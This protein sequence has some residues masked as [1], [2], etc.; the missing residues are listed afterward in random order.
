M[1]Q[2]RYK[3]I[4]LFLMLI[5]LGTGASFAQD[6]S[7]IS[8]VIKEATSNKPLQSVLVSVAGKSTSTNQ[9]GLFEIDAV[10]L[11]ERMVV[12]IPG[13]TT[14]IIHLNGKTSFNIYMVR[15]EFKSFDDE[16]ITPLGAVSVRDNVMAGS[17]ITSS[18][19][20]QKANSSLDLMLQGKF[21]GA[22]VIAGSGM[23][24]SKSYVNLRGLSS[25]Y[26]SNDPLVIIDDMIH[27]IHYANYSAISGFTH[28]PFD[29]VDPEDV[30]SVSVFADGNA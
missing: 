23:P 11:N 8:G 13:Y 4:V 15:K 2:N 7:K 5:I 27:P 22:Q 12:Q 17:Y 9:D 10:D 18:D 20:S 30:A 19:V 28:N 14:R 24:G 3:S 26:G 16:I 25:L 29:I 21:A 6:L 1:I